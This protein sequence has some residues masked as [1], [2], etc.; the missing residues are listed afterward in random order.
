MSPPS[1]V[2]T[3][4]SGNWRVTRRLLPHLLRYKSRIAI[5]LVFLI[6]ARVA[7]VSV[8]VVLKQIV[9]SLDG[10]ATTAMLVLPLAALIAYGALRFAAILFNELRNVIFIKASVQI[11]QHVSASVFNHLH[12]LSLSFHLDRKTGALSRDVERGTTSISYFLRII[13]FSIVPVIFEI[14]AVLFI[15]W[16]QFDFDFVLVTMSII[17]LYVVFTFLI[18]RWRTR[19]RVGNECR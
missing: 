15:L 17:L 13:V 16:K 1:R 5:G 18:T 14:V 10:N 4:E 2:H 9:D 3:A 8:P 12:Q 19:F 7:N 11:I 6:A